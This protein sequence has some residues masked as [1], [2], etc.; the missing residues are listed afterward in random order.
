MPGRRKRRGNGS[1]K[2]DT[3]S[4]TTRSKAKKQRQ[5]EQID[6]LVSLSSPVKKLSSVREERKLSPIRDDTSPQKQAAI[7]LPERE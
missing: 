3:D 2:K 7:D 6:S 5:Q 1:P 4:S